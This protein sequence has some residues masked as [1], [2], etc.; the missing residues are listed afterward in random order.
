[1]RPWC[2]LTRVCLIGRY[3]WVPQKGQ[4][5]D[6]VSILVSNHTTAFTEPRIF[7]WQGAKCLYLKPAW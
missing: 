6:N 3:Y 1:M 2:M 4:M 5:A 7:T